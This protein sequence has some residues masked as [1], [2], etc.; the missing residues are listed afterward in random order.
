MFKVFKESIKERRIY[1]V[2]A[3]LLGVLMPLSVLGFFKA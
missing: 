1:H 2:G 3:P